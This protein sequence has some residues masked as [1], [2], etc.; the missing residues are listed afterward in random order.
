MKKMNSGRS[1]RSKGTLRKYAK[2]ALG[3]YL[4]NKLKSEKPQK[5]VEVE[6]EEEIILN[7]PVEIEV[8]EGSSMMKLRKI[9]MGMLVGAT[10]VYAFKKYT[11]KKSGYKIEVQ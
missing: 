6:P 3:A 1:A 2:L 9:I 7:K 10:A 4:L 11:A 8:G 5:K